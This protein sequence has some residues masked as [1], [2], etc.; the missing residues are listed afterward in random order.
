MR[1]FIWWSL[2]FRASIRWVIVV[3]WFGWL[4][5]VVDVFSISCSRAFSGVVW[6]CF[7]REGLV[8]GG[9]NVVICLV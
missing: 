8:G 1:D 6:W 2:V 9:G 5:I 3:G 7:C 4:V